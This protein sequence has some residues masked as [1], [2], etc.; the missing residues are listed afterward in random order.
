MFFRNDNMFQICK[1]KL[2]N[3]MI[4]YNVT[5]NVEKEV[6]EVWVNWMK[7]THIPEIL[8]TGLFH[9]HISRMN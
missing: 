5:V 6:E 7:E 9:E 8:A 3:A 1:K 4:I 2:K